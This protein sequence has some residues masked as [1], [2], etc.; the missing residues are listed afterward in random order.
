[1]CVFTSV[2][3]REPNYCDVKCGPELP[4]STISSGK[5]TFAD[6]VARLIQATPHLKYLQP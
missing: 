2:E 3:Y 5:Q 1:M 4:I 6:R